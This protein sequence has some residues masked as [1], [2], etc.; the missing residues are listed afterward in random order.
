MLNGQ[1]VTHAPATD[2]IFLDEV[3]DAVE[4][5]RSR[6]GRDTPS[7]IPARRSACT[8]LRNQPF[9][10]A[11]LVDV[12]SEPASQHESAVRPL[13]CRRRDV[14]WPTSRARRSILHT[15]P[16]TPGSQLHTR[17]AISFASSTVDEL[18]ATVSSLRNVA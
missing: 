1:P 9:Q 10:L 5:A 11:G 4:Y 16:G 18:K 13:G 6:R 8:I 17:D 7:D 12:F 3:D 14:V 15:Q 2:A